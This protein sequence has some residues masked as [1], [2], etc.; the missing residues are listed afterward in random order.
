MENI[1]TSIK[2][3][4]NYFRDPNSPPDSNRRSITEEVGTNDCG[5]QSG[6]HNITRHP[7]STK[8]YV[9]LI[10]S[11]SVSFFFFCIILAILFFRWGEATGVL[12]AL[13]NER[14][15][16]TIMRDVEPTIMGEV[17][18]TIMGDVEPT[19]AGDVEPTIVKEVISSGLEDEIPSW[20]NVKK[21]NPSRVV[22]EGTGLIVGFE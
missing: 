2:I 4:D 3:K 19:I 11:V 8:I 17:E 16:P 14:V 6:D 7:N 21:E 20:L 1:N 13:S 5:N 15:E 18:P 22:I 9:A 10:V 12:V